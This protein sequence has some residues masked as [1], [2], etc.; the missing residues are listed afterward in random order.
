[1]LPHNGG[2]GVEPQPDTLVVVRVG[3]GT[4]AEHLGRV[5]DNLGRHAR[6]LVYHFNGEEVAFYQEACPHLFPF[7]AELDGVIEHRNQRLLEVAH[8][9]PRFTQCLGGVF[10]VQVDVLFPGKHVYGSNGPLYRRGHVPRFQVQPQ[11]PLFN[12]VDQHELLGKDPEPLLAFEDGSIQLLSLVYAQRALVLL[13]LS[14]RPLDNAD[15]RQEVVRPDSNEIF[16]P[17]LQPAAPQ[18]GKQLIH[19]EKGEK[20][21]ND[22]ANAGRN[23]EFLTEYDP[24]NFHRVSIPV[25]AT[26]PLMRLFR[27]EPV[28]PTALSVDIGTEFVKVLLFEVREGKGYV[29]GQGKAR[30]RLSD[31][32]AGHV[33]DIHG[34]IATAAKAIDSAFEQAAGRQAEQVIVGI[35]GELVKGTT[36]TTTLT[37]QHANTPITEAEL[38]TI[39]SAAQVEIL[40]KSRK[41][42][43]WE[44]GYAEIDVELVNSAVV[45]VKI[46]GYKVS[47]PIG[48]QGRQVEVSIYTSYA[49]NVHLGALQ[50][51]VEGLDLDLIS[52]ATEPYAVARCLGDV[53][54]GD[55]SSIFIDVGG[56]TTDIAVVR[57][58]GLEGTKMFALGGR[59]FT[60]R[61]AAE[62]KLSFAEAEK[63]KLAYADERLEKKDQE[64]VAEFIEQDV[65]VWLSGVQLAL[66][67]FASSERFADNKLL[68]TKIYLCGGGSL[69]P[70]LKKALETKGWTKGLP[71]AKQPEVQYIKPDQVSTIVD[72]TQSLTNVQ[73]VTPMA[74]ANIALD[75]V[76]TDTAVSTTMNRLIRGLRS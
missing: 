33:T 9:E 34:V 22:R 57:G 66:E 7:R 43:A 58:G 39:I 30:Q 53:E 44:T 47:N 13:E 6:P 56:G 4:A 51:I 28:T 16:L 63:I 5:A 45:S 55:I 26:I 70:D 37:R 50:S 15:R 8:I 19:N 48:F 23:R 27:R 62:Q 11:L 10:K 17:L 42:L 54:S 20:R 72:T 31:M 61:I 71:F 52:V 49:P 25:R 73:D 32:Q 36:T 40:Q 14:E 67:E 18:A 3:R 68:P 29:L 74:L 35:A 2:S 75:L 64:R 76:G 41:E 60:K 38:R 12:L 69:L 46:D 65:D 1:M 21:P 59:V 24:S